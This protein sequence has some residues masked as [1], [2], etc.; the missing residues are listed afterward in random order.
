M[1]SLLEGFAWCGLDIFDDFDWSEFLSVDC[2]VDNC[3]AGMQVS[4]LGDL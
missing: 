2:G 4:M 1:R 3:F